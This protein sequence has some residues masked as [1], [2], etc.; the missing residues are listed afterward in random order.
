MIMPLFLLVTL[1]LILV[2][3]PPPSKKSA[4]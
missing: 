2:Q 3:T 4:D 1:H